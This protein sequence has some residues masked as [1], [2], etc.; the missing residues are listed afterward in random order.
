[1][2]SDLTGLQATHIQYNTVQTTLT[3]HHLISINR[4]KYT[5]ISVKW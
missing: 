2:T 1:M 3:T 4:Y 5:Q